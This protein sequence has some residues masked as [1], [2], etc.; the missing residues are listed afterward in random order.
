MANP[1]FATL[2]SIYGKTVF[3]A[4]VSSTD[5]QLLLN[6]ASS[7]KLLKINT[8]VIANINGISSGNITIRIKNSAGSSLYS[9]LAY[10]VTVP[11]DSSFVAISKDTPIYLR[12]DKAIYL[13]A[14]ISGYLSATCSYEEI[15]DA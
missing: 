4:D 15:D 12:E 11:A 13:Q 7:N 1:H 6:A 2:T 14:S 10:T 8:L 9:T 5:S 3:D